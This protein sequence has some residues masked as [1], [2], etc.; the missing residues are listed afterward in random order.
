MT[1]ASSHQEPIPTL[2]RVFLLVFLLSGLLLAVLSGIGWRDILHDGDG[3]LS[4]SDWQV[5]NLTGFGA[6]AFFVAFP[7]WVWLAGLKQF[8]TE[9]GSPQEEPAGSNTN[10]TATSKASAPSARY[11]EIGR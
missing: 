9:G 10:S 1:S 3:S 6:A 11:M 4:A 2:G 8:R 5:L 7:A